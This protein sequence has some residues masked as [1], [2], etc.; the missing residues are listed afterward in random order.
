[1]LANLRFAL[2][3]LR[4]SPGFTA[5]AVL[6]LAIGIGCVIAFF[7]VASSVLLRPLPFHEPDRLVR[8]HEG[9]AHQF[10]LADLPA[11]D[12]IRMMRDNRSFSAVAGFID[13]AYEMNGAGTAFQVRAERVTASL[14]PI[15]PIYEKTIIGSEILDEYTSV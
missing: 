5:A 10:D 11:P 14:F 4:R 15:N 12:V 3:Q 8:L 9:V 1:M 13:A 6:T 2:R 7:S